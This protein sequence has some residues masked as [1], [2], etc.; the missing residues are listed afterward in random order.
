MGAAIEM[1]AEYWEQW[2]SILF[3]W[4]SDIYGNNQWVKQ[5]VD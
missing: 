2:V 4:I 3:P 5:L 1:P